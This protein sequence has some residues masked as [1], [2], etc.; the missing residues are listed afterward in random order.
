MEMFH[1]FGFSERVL[2][3][4]TSGLRKDILLERRKRQ[5]HLR[6]APH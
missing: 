2:K 3:E 6:N 1:A 4:W 5:R